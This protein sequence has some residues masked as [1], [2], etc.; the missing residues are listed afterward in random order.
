MF[1]FFFFAM[2]TIDTT[3]I[4]H[5]FDE[6]DVSYRKYTYNE[7]ERKLAISYCSNIHYTMQQTIYINLN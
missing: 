7:K 3:S 5:P 4:H 2:G 6:G 1:F